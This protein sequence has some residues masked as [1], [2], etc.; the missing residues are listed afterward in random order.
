MSRMTKQK[1]ERR[2]ERLASGK[3]RVLHPYFKPERMEIPNTP[4]QLMFSRTFQEVK[5][6]YAKRK[7]TAPRRERRRRMISLARRTVKM[8]REQNAQRNDSVVQRG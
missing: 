3:A 5:V 8:I 1:I 2:L 6:E 7:V 4:R